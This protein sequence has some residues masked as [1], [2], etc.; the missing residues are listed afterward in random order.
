MTGQNVGA[1]IHDLD[2]TLWVG[3][4]GIEP[5]VDELRTQLDDAELVKVKFLRAARGGTDTESLA[6]DLAEAAD[7]EVVQTRGHTAVFA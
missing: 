3:K 1:A 2:V 4:K 6:N 7:A 5:A